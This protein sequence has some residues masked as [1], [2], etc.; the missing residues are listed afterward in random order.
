MQEDSK[1]KKIK[2]WKK[3][4]IWS[5]I[6]LTFYTVC[7][8]FILPPV[9]KSISAK[10]LSENLH[11]EVA[12]EDI[13]INPYK[14]SMT[15]KGFVVREPD[16]SKPFASFDSLYLNLQIISALKLGLIVKELRI[17]RPYV[18]IVRKDETHFNFS[19]LL[20][21]KD[22]EKKEPSKPIRFS[23]GNI[24]ISDAS[25]D[26]SDI[27][28]NK[29]HKI[30]DVQVT[31]PFLSNF[32]YHTKINVEP[33]FRA[34]INGTPFS[35]QG[36]TKPFAESLETVFDVNIRD[37]NIP[38]YLSYLP[39]KR[40]F[41]MSSGFLDTRVKLSYL[42]WKNR[43][44]ALTLTGSITLKKVAVEDKKGDPLLTLPKLDVFIAPSGI[45]SGKLNI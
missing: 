32:Q 3:I 34:K 9:L 19:D 4:F 26:L 30:T 18:H 8:F 43:K 36:K 41:E 40:N 24:Q 15:I 37:F 31:I 17:D 6:I 7:G 14:L 2:Y 27:P 21:E 45:F 23:L 33:S 44:P 28:K 20:K 10:K 5:A 1:T 13:K 42:Q 12:I 35:S 39:F 25:A 29:T 38:Y 11:R 22:S 16:G